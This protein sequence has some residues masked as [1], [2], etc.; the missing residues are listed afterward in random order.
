[1]LQTDEPISEIAMKTGFQDS[2]NVS[3]EFKLMKGCT[4]SEYRKNAGYEK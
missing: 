1:L 4:P 3:R 2:K